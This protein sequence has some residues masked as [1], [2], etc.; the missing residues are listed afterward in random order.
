MAP[1]VGGSAV[2]FAGVK[3]AL[4]AAGVRAAD[5]AGAHAGFRPHSGRRGAVYGAGALWRAAHLR[6]ASARLPLTRGP[7]GAFAARPAFSAKLT[8]RPPLARCMLEPTPLYGGNADFLDA[9]YEQ[10]LRDP[11]SVDERWRR[12]F[13]QLPAQPA[14]SVRTGRCAPRSRSARPRRRQVRLPADVGRQRQAGGRLASDPGVDQPRPPAGE[15]RSAR[16]HAAPAAARARP[17]LLRPDAGRSRHRVLH[18]QP[19]R[20]GAGTH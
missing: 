20:R 15:H 11:Q 4:T 7:R 16:A 9:L 17:R 10:Y 18:R 2:A 12:Y 6:V 1:L 8:A 3:I 14:P 19:H 5:A 13:A